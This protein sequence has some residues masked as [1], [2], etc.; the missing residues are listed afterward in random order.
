MRTN[1]L[2]MLD[3]FLGDE[4]F[5][6]DWRDVCERSEQIRILDT[7]TAARDPRRAVRWRIAIAGAIVAAAVIAPLTAFAF[8]LVSGP[9]AGHP[10]FQSGP[11]EIPIPSGFS[12]AAGS[13]TMLRIAGRLRP[14]S[15]VIAADFRLPRFVDVQGPPLPPRGRFTIQVRHFPANGS[16]LHWP[17]VTAL[18]LPP[19]SGKT[20]LVRG[21]L[22]TEAL[23]IEIR[24]GSTPTPQQ[25]GSASSFVAGIRNTTIL[26]PVNTN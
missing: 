18:S 14:V 12:A 5:E 24:F 22:G 17:S 9:P 26:M 4:P 25:L 13:T 1:P 2:S 19:S 8:G 15:I 20:I 11:I 7:E 16:A 10:R 23:L 21:R 6:L 3:G